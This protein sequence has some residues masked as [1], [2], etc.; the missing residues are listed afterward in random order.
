MAFGVN[1]RNKIVDCGSLQPRD[2]IMRTYHMMRALFVMRE[3]NMG[4]YGDM[5]NI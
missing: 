2:S 5:S 1:P 3:M 4:V